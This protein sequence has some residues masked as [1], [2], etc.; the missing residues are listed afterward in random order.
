MIVFVLKRQ[1]YTFLCTF[2]ILC[3][4]QFV[5]AC[6]VKLHRTSCFSF[7]HK[8]NRKSFAVHYVKEGPKVDSTSIEPQYETCAEVKTTDEPDY[9]AGLHVLVLMITCF[10]SLF[11]LSTIANGL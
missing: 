10:D 5:C 8:K 7:R 11:C 2:T 9:V 6:E 3:F 1:V 4:K